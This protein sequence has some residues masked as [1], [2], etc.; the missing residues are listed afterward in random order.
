MDCILKRTAYTANGIFSELRDSS[1]RLIAVT[2]EHAYQQPDGSYSPKLP[3]GSYLCQLGTHQLDHGGPKQL[4]AVMGVPEH[5]GICFHIGNY[6]HDSDGCIL[7]GEALGQNMILNS[8]E[9]FKSFM[10]LQGGQQNFTLTV[11]P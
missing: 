9:A 11:A 6:N 7:L 4:F 8:D 10:A 2:L 5:E 1:G 3:P